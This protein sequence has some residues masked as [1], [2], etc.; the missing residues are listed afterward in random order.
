MLET[1]FGMVDAAHN[2]GG[3][4]QRSIAFARL[5]REYREEFRL[6]NPPA[7]VQW[8]LINTLGRLHTRARS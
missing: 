2:H 1:F 4:L 3:K 7:A 6:T 5:L 8:L